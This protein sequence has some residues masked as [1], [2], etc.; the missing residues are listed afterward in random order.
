MS[1]MIRNCVGGDE[2][3]MDTNIK[4]TSDELQ[5]HLDELVV[6]YYT[7]IVRTLIVWNASLV[8][9]FTLFCLVRREP[10]NSDCNIFPKS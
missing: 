3:R 10:Q 8:V 4:V 2:K 7:V 5:D 6:L 9:F 1:N